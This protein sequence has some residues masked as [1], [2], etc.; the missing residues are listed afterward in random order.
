VSAPAAVVAA[1]AAAAAAVA[2]RAAH[3]VLL[4]N[5]T[6]IFVRRPQDW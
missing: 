2:P 3:S 6:V 4:F 5:L 1:A